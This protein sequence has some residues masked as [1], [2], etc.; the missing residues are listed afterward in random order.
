MTIDYNEISQRIIDEV[1][2]ISFNQFV[3][4]VEVGAEDVAELV[5]EE[6]REKS[7]HAILETIAFYRSVSKDEGFLFPDGTRFLFNRGTAKIVAIEQS[8]QV[9]TLALDESLWGPNRTQKGDWKD[10]RLAFPYV[11]FICVISKKGHKIYV[12]FRNSPL[13][14]LDSLLYRAVFS[15][16]NDDDSVCQSELTYKFNDPV[17]VKI[18]TA[19]ADFWQS[20]FNSDLDTQWRAKDEID[21]RLQLT[22]WRALSKVEPLFPC[23]IKWKSVG[24]LGGR[25]EFASG[26]HGTLDCPSVGENAVSQRLAE[27]MGHATTEISVKLRKYLKTNRLERLYPRDVQKD[28]KGVVSGLCSEMETT[29]RKLVIELGTARQRI[30]RQ[31]EDVSWETQAGGIWE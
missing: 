26:E 30:D 1:V 19:I 23:S 31:S 3:R 4:K 28:L 18:E 21:S 5:V 16:L 8:P 15:N 10:F 25:M 9:R 20:T 22:T 13:K 29:I 14:N 12:Y 7:L 24:T 27:L 2:K 11:I 6:L 17:N